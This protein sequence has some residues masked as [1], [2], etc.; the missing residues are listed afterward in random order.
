MARGRLR[1]RCGTS[2]GTPTKWFLC[3]HR[4]TVSRHGGK[5]ADTR[6]T[7]STREKITTVRPDWRSPNRRC[8]SGFS[9][10]AE[11]N[12]SVC[13]PRGRPY[14]RKYVFLSLLKGSIAMRTL[15]LLP[16]LVIALHLSA[17][18]MTGMTDQDREQIGRASC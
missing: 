5:R 9:R 11:S 18:G 12:A 1:Q 13:E 14:Y 8:Q 2:M 4:V 15:P 7:P 16:L 3:P 6:S 17:T 10:N